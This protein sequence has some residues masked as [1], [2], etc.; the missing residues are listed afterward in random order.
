MRFSDMMGSGEQ[1]SRK[2]A[3]GDNLVSDALAPYLDAVVPPAPPSP[4][5]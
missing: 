3:E 4:A 1:R 2:P 5:G